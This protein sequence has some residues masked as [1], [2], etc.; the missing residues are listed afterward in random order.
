MALRTIGAL[1]MRLTGN[2]QGNYYF[3]SLSTGRII[4]RA[5]TTKLPMPDDVIEHVHAQLA[6]R[7]KRLTPVC[8]FLI[9]IK[10]PMAQSTNTMT[11]TTMPMM[12]TVITC[13][14]R[15]TMIRSAS[16]MM[17]NPTMMMILIVM[18]TVITTPPPEDGGEDDTDSFLVYD[19][20][21]G[22]VGSE[23]KHP[24][25]G[26]DDDESMEPGEV[27]PNDKDR[28]TGVDNDRTT[29]VD[30]EVAEDG[31]TTGVDAEVAEDK[32]GS[33]A[34]LEREMEEKYGPRTERY[35]MRQRGEPDYSHLFAKNTHADE[36][37]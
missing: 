10:C 32:G 35:N 12:M 7:H 24:P 8:C 6:R 27:H 15:M 29:G 5:H 25:G 16:R 36:P 11:T 14:G 31:R 22:S 26:G 33:Q 18:T 13:P 2:A 9:T 37:F 3:F 28:T 17:M 4:N 23:P 20:E 21:D 19:S 34:A 30:A 1:A